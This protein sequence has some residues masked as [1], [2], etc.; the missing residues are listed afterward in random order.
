MPFFEERIQD[1]GGEF[2]ANK[3]SQGSWS[4]AFVVERQP[5]DI[6]KRVRL[7]VKGLHGTFPS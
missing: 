1:D 7:I 3:V 2:A 5:A 4:G 6:W